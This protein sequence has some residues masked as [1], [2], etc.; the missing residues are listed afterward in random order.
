MER[1]IRQKKKCIYDLISLC[2]N[3][4]QKQSRLKDVPAFS[5]SCCWETWMAKGEG[6]GRGWDGEIASPTQLT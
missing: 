1:E 2:F 5:F 4:R 3:N 6:G